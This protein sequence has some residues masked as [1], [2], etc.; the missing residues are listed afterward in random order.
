M[1]FKINEILS[2][3]RNVAVGVGEKKYTQLSEGR[4]VHKNTTKVIDLVWTTWTK[5]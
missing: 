4:A 2:I 3:D 1:Y 5:C